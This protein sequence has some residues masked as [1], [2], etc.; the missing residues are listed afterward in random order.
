MKWLVLVAG[1]CVLWGCSSGDDDDDDGTLEGA[2]IDC[3]W[4][5]NDNCWHPTVESSASCV[6]PAGE[7]GV[8]NADGRSCTYASGASITFAR[9]VVLPTTSD[10]DLADEWDFSVKASDGSECLRFRSSEAGGKTLNVRG[11]T[12]V[13]TYR[14][15]DMQVICPNGEKYAGSALSLLEC[16]NFFSDSSVHAYTWTQTSVSFSLGFNGDDSVPVFSCAR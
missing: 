3:A 16:E 15:F 13:E 5:A 7:T 9:P 4:L 6:P 11:Q 14:G 10:G 12:Y 8:L 2:P 1:A